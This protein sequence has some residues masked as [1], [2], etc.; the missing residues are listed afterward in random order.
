VRGQRSEEVRRRLDRDDL[1]ARA[2]QL[3]R[4]QRVVADVRADV[5]ERV[6]RAQAL[7]NRL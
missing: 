5:D 4:E 2:D 6:S 3:R 7:R 1:P